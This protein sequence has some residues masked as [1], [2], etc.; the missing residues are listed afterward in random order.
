MHKNVRSSTVKTVFE[1]NA[2]LKNYNAKMEEIE[3]GCM[4]AC[5]RQPCQCQVEGLAGGEVST[6]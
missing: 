5:V 4:H 6:R 3:L 1:S 2:S